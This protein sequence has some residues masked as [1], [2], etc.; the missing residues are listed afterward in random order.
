[1]SM[2]FINKYLFFVHLSTSPKCELFVKLKNGELHTG[3]SKPAISK[4]AGEPVQVK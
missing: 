1:M 2:P 4:F 3:L